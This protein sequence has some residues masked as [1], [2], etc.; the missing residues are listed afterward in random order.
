MKQQPVVRSG[1]RFD[2]LGMSYIALNNSRPADVEF[3]AGEHKVMARIVTEAE[4]SRYFVIFNPERIQLWTGVVRHG[5]IFTSDDRSY[6][7]ACDSRPESD[8]DGFVHWV[9]AIDITDEPTV[10][11]Y[12][13]DRRQLILIDSRTV[14]VTG[15]GQLSE[16]GAVYL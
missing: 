16:K 2:Q 11:V 7:A 15:R 12:D 4:G 6:L 14:Q 13:H 10:A 5:E 9:I 8:S 1:Q 3:L